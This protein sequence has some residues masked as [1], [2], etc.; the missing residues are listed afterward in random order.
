MNNRMYLLAYFLEGGMK[1][2]ELR[3]GCGHLGAVSAGKV[4]PIGVEAE[5]MGFCPF[6]HDQA[7][8]DGQCAAF[9]EIVLKPSDCRG[10]LARCQQK[11][12]QV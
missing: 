4:F 1:S 10:V 8:F 5:Q 2:V 6:P 12:V 7:P 9:G 3:P 11:G